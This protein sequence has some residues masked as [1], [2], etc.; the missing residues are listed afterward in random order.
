MRTYEQVQEIFNKQ[1]CKLL[2]TEYKN[3][4]TKLHYIA[5]CGHEHEISL[6]N[7]MKGKGLVCKEC[8]YKKI[9]ATNKYSYEYVKN[10]FEREGCKLISQEYA[11]SSKA[12]LRYVAQCGHENEILF[13]KFVSGGG[14]VCNKCSKS[15][16][17]DYDYVFNEF[18]KRQCVLLEDIYINCK[19]PMKYIATCGHESFISF[20][21]LINSKTVTLKCKK[22]QSFKHYE[23]DEVRQMFKDNGCELLSKEYTNRKSKLKY[24]AQ[25]GHTE[26]IVFDKFLMGHGRKCK[27]C[28]IP[29]GTEHFAYNPN[30]TEADR[31]KRDMQNGKIRILR[32]KVFERDNY[33]CQV[34]GDSKGGNLEA[35]HME[36]WNTDIDNRFNEDNLITL[37]K[38]CHKNFHSEYGYGNNTREQ[39]KNFLRCYANTEG[40]TIN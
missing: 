38:T 39:F 27:K 9:S 3:T 22:C 26:T 25:C 18:S 7:F 10:T 6:D 19:E 40:L 4:K 13:N 30:L 5:Q 12:K 24:V 36:S 28:A 23:I 16:R 32:N 15:I 20:D 33:T 14:R 1:G 34:C 35:H 31:E 8:R 29:S 17:Y 21:E 2:S 37:C 11:G